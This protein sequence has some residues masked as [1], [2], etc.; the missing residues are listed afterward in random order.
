MADALGQLISLMGDWVAILDEMARGGMAGM[1]P[2]GQSLRFDLPRVESAVL[3]CLCSSHPEVCLLGLRP[4]LL[5]DTVC[6]V[7]W[8]TPQPHQRCPFCSHTSLRHGRLGF[9]ASQLVV[10]T[11]CSAGMYMQ[12]LEHELRGALSPMILGQ[13]ILPQLYSSCHSSMLCCC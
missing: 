11:M 1:E 5:C 12:L 4:V 3:A 7:V 8:L 13:G 10:C 6:R 9:T 2:S